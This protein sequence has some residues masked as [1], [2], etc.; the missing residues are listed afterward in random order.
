ME[1]SNIKPINIIGITIVVVFS[2]VSFLALVAVTRGEGG[3]PYQVIENRDNIAEAQ[4]NAAPAH[5]SLEK[6]KQATAA[7]VEAEREAQSIVDTY[8]STAQTARQNICNLGK[9]YCTRENL[10]PLNTG[11]NLDEFF[12]QSR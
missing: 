9:E 3:M 10:D 2:L 1:L 8:S 6:A 4:K 5:L 11:V 7:A 12:T